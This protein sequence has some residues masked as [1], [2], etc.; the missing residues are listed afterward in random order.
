MY[1]DLLSKHI[2]HLGQD[3]YD[4][5]YFHIRNDNHLRPVSACKDIGAGSRAQ[6]SRMSGI[7]YN[8]C[9]IASGSWDGSVHGE[10][11]VAAM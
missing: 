3:L 4:L 1:T 10:L 11:T 9:Q 7:F 6:E 2:L 8:N 5:P